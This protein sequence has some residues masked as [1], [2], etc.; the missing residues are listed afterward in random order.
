VISCSKQSRQAAI[1][2]SGENCIRKSV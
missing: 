2:T 1:D